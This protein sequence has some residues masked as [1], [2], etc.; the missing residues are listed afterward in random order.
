MFS[1]IFRKAGG[2]EKCGQDLK[3]ISLTLFVIDSKALYSEK[4]IWSTVVTTKSN[5][6]SFESLTSKEELEDV[7]LE[8]KVNKQLIWR[9][10]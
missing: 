6:C 10:K 7:E 5:K 8:K 4:S 1:V 2:P 9:K 3:I